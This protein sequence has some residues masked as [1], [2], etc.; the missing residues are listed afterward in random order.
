[1][2]ICFIV[3]YYYPHIGGA[4]ILFQHLAEGLVQQGHTCEIV[5]CRLPGVP[6]NEIINGVH[7]HRIWVPGAGDRYWFTV[8]SAFAAWKH[9]KNADILHTMVY[10]GALSAKILSLLK[11]KPVVIHVF[12]VLRSN[13]SRTGI[14]PLSAFLFKTIEKLVLSIPYDAYS[15]ISR[16]TL[17]LLKEWGIPSRKLFLAYPGIDYALFNPG[18]KGHTRDSIRGKLGI[19]SDQFLFSFYGRPGFVK[20]VD[21]LVRAVPRIKEMIPNATLLLI[22]SRKPAAGFSRIMKTITSLGLIL[23]RDVIVLDP[24][25]RTEL[26]SY[27]QASDC[28]VIPSISEGFGFTCVEACSMGRP[29]VATAVGS[30]PEVIFGRYVLV[31]PMDPSALADGVDRIYRNQYDTTDTRKFLWEDMVKKHVEIYESL[32]AS[33]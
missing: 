20:G 14:N 27:I 28:I 21:H 33:N 22:L 29:V 15:C 13:W 11:R 32:L 26:P 31:K 8:I 2:K 30:I 23:G 17:S 1:M 18:N 7:V 19:S 9:V 12:E 25:M 24:V 3:E 16:N 10:N 4:E 6:R 5:T